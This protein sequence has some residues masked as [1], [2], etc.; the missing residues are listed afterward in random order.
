MPEGLRCRT[1][2]GAEELNS[3]RAEVSNSQRGRGVE[4][5]KGQRCRTSK[6]A[7]IARVA[8]LS[9]D[10]LVQPGMIKHQTA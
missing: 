1:A 5:P 8:K 9:S 4:H 7:G 3:Q 6:G 2:K 10:Y